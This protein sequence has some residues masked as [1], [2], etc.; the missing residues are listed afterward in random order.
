M[1]QLAP[2]GVIMIWYSYSYNTCNAAPS[3]SHPVM[4]SPL[5]CWDPY[6]WFFGELA[7]FPAFSR[8]LF[9][10]LF[11]YFHGGVCSSSGWMISDR[12]IDRLIGFN[13]E[14][15]E[16]RKGK[17]SHEENPR[18]VDIDWL[19]TGSSAKYVCSLEREGRRG[20]R[21]LR[22]KQKLAQAAVQER[23]C[24]LY[25]EENTVRN[26]HPFPTAKGRRGLE[27][28]GGGRREGGREEKDLRRTPAR[29]ARSSRSPTT[30]GRGTRG[31]G[32]PA[33]AGRGRSRSRGRGGRGQKWRR[34]AVWGPSFFVFVV[35]LVEWMFFVRGGLERVM[36]KKIVVVGRKGSWWCMSSTRS[37]DLKR[38][39]IV[40]LRAASGAERVRL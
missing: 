17:V 15:W 34:R 28:K 39:I 14:T 7:R 18:L 9:S 40:K 4:E 6:P 2:L 29:S 3:T 22:R 32:S 37:F 35:Q 8:S 19:C 27:K 11:F 16:T 24:G 26:N 21:N 5:Y 30:S 33:A 31:W 13:S 20:R 12:S 10:F 1:P 25:I 36:W 23:D 38:W